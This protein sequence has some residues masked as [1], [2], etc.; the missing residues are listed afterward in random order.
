MSRAEIQRIILGLV[1]TL[2]DVFERHELLFWLDSGSL[3]GAYRERTVIPHDFDADVGIDAATYE[4]LRD[5]DLALD[6]PSGYTL[7]VFDAKHLPH[8][9]RNAGIPGRF[10]HT[11][12]GLYVDLFVFF[13]S[14]T[15]KQ[16]LV[17]G[18]IPSSCFGDCHHCSK[19][20]SRQW[21]FKIP[22]TWIYPLASCDFGGRNVSCPAQPDKYLEHLYGSDF[23]TP[24]EE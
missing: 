2:A 16:E 8:G 15:I 7:Q 12:S 11:E 9:T 21:E 18:P 24:R 22:K 19:V 17:Y 1:W 6:I 14:R 10:V 4:R 13:E 5:E 23:M 20:A 3:L